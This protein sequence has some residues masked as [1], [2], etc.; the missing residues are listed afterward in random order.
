MMLRFVSNRTHQ[1]VWSS[2]E[3]PKRPTISVELHS[4]WYGL[5]LLVPSSMDLFPIIEELPFPYAHEGGYAIDHA[6]N[7]EFVRRFC[8]EKHY[9]LDEL[10]E[11]LIVG[12]YTI[13]KES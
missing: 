1:I 13:A 10:A 2:S 7:P 3:G 8:E 5:I 6:P 11:E 9:D 12:R 4:K